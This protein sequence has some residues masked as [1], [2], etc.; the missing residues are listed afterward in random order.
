MTYRY[1]LDGRC[2]LVAVVPEIGVIVEGDV[3]SQLVVILF[4]K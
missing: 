1:G 4:R 2:R 3:F